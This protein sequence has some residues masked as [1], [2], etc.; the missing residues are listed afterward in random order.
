MNECKEDTRPHWV[1][2][3]KKGEV[4][5]V[6]SFKQMYDMIAACARA[7]GAGYTMKTLYL[8]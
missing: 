3:F 2:K 6:A 4:V 1:V 7:S 5:F 8:G